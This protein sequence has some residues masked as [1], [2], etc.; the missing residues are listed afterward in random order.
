MINDYDPRRPLLPTRALRTR[1]QCG[2]SVRIASTKDP[3]VLAREA[4]M[5]FAL[6]THG[7]AGLERLFLWLH[8]FA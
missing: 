3:C 7:G 6:S 4:G 1:S 2:V 8:R 5:P